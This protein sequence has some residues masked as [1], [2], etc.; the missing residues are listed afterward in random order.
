MSMQVDW[1]NVRAKRK[2]RKNKKNVPVGKFGVDSGQVLI[3][4]PCYLEEWQVKKR[5]DE[6]GYLSELT[7]HNVATTTLN[8]EFQVGMFE[9]VASST[10]YGDGCYTVYAD[11]NKDGL[12]EQLTIRFLK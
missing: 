2:T 6:K 10:G 12:V 1:D 9:G 11:F 7:Y 5:E 8:E 3:V 4:D